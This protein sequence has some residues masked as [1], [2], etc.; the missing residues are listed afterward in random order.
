MQGGFYFKKAKQACSFI[1]KFSV[2]TRQ[3]SFEKA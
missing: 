2:C 1:R 3:E